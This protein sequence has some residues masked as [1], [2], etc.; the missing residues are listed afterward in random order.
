MSLTTAGRIRLALLRSEL[1]RAF[2]QFQHERILGVM[3]EH[4]PMLERLQ[5]ALASAHTLASE[6]HRSI[7]K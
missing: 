1:R 6:L 4:E 3:S 5:E 7:N 2:H